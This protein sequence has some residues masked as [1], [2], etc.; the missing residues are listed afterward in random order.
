MECR[1]TWRGFE[2]DERGGVLHL[3]NRCLAVSSSVLNMHLPDIISRQ[4]S[5]EYGASKTG[6]VGQE[7]GDKSVCQVLDVAS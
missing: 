5:G 4:M 2:S 1:R 6:G 3:G 7:V